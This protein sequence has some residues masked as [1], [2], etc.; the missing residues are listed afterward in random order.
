MLQQHYRHRIRPTVNGAAAVNDLLNTNPPD[1]PKG[2]T[3]RNK[4]KGRPA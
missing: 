1:E 4:S 3:R 2:T